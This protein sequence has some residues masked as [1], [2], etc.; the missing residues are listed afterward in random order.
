M[1]ASRDD[2]YI[3]FERA[4]S[5]GKNWGSQFVDAGYAGHINADSGLGDWQFGQSLLEQLIDNA[6]EQASAAR[7]MR[8][9][10]PL[11]VKEARPSPAMHP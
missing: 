1:V 7:Q 4:H 5:I 8:P 10:L 2:P 11:T 9:A 3:F 6:R